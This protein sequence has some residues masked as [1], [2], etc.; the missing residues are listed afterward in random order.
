[1][2]PAEA[3]RFGVVLV[4]AALAAAGRL[5]FLWAPNVALTYFLAFLAGAAFG[6]RAGFLVGVLSMAATDLMLTAFHPILL[7]NTLPMG[8]LGVLGAALAG[9][10]RAGGVAGPSAAAAAGLVGTFL[11]SALADVLTWLLLYA[12]A[13]GVATTRSFAGLVLLGLAFNV[14]PAAVNAALFGVATRPCL[15][16]LEAAGLAT[17]YSSEKQKKGQNMY[18]HSTASPDDSTASSMPVPPSAPSTK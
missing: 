4:F 12:G 5:A 8:A 14:V 15:A 7:A 2:R 10:V 3:R 18:R 1:M 17:A 6:A 13:E 16:A 11:F 9:P